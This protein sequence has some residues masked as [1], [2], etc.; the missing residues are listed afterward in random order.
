MLRHV[1][2]ISNPVAS[3]VTPDVEARVLVALGRRLRV[4]LVRTER[5]LH[6]L[7]LAREA[8]TGGVDGIVVLAGDGTMN[9]VVNGVG[10][11]VPIGVLPGGGTSVLARATGLSRHPVRAAERVADALA[12]GRERHLALGILNGRRFAF[13]AGVGLDAAIVRRVDN[14]GREN[15]RRPGDSYF[16]LQVARVMGERQYRSPR[17][18]LEVGERSERVSFLVAANLHPWS[19][20]G[21]LPLRAAPLAEPEGGLDLIAPRRLRLRDTPSLA[22]S[23]LVT[24]HHA[25][26]VGRTIAYYHD[27]E[28]AI[29][30]CDAPLPAHVD[31]DDIGD[32]TEVRLGVDHAGMRIAV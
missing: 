31:G 2:V 6:A 10:A 14:A 32:V 29:L 9:E 11:T 24:G 23:L 15:G 12:E 13:A 4:D 8:V 22:V 20:A 21:P 5:S 18:T 30:T 28:S 7:E 27:I 3:G 19:Y 17:A 16:A 26:G 25:K 1:V